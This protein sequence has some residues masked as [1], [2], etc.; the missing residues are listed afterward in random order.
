MVY[1]WYLMIFWEVLLERFVGKLCG[2]CC[3]SFGENEINVTKSDVLGLTARDGVGV[4]WQNGVF[5]WGFSG[6]GGVVRNPPPLLRH[7]EVL[8]SCFFACMRI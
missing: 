7:S 3:G 4:Q 5:V 1:S 2:G 8:R 6:F